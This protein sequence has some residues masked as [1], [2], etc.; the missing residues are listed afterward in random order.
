MVDFTYILNE[1]KYIT[2]YFMHT[3]L[4]IQQMNTLIFQVT[5]L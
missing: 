3:F 4:N 1:M 2:K 5:T